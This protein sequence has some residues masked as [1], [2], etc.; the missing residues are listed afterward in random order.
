MTGQIQPVNAG[1]RPVGPRPPMPMPPQSAAAITPKEMIGIVKRHILLIISL[2]TIGLFAGGVGWYLCKKYIPKYSTTAFINILPDQEKD[3]MTMGTSSP[4]KDMYYA[5]RNTLASTIKQQGMLEELLRKDKIRET[6]WFRQFSNKKNS[7][8]EAV[9]DL[10]DNLGAGANRDTN[11]LKISMKCGDAKES[12][13]IVDEMVR[14]FI[15]KRQIMATSDIKAQL[16]KYNIQLRNLEKAVETAEQSMEGIRLGSQFSNLSSKTYFRSYIEEKVSSLEKSYSQLDTQVKQFQTQINTFRER[17][18]G[19]FDEVVREQMERDPIASGMRSRIASMQPHLA[20]LL[21]KFGDGHR[22]VEE[23]RVAI[24]QMNTDLAKRQVFIAETQR[25]SSLRQAEDMM[26]MYKTSLED[27]EAQRNAAMDEHKQLEEV[28][29]DY[30]KYEQIRETKQ[31]E[32]DLLSAHVQKLQMNHD[33]PLISKVQS[34]GPAPIPLRMKFPDIKMF[35]PAGLMLG[36]MLGAGI[37]F[38]VELLNDLLRTPT[39]ISK[40]LHIPLLGSIY[41]YDE[42]EDLDD[43]DLCHVVRQ[44]PYSIMSESYRQLRTNLQLSGSAQPHKT[45]FITSGAA[46]DGKTSV[47]VNLVSTLVAEDRKVLFID[48]NFRRPMSM[49]V[50]PHAENDGSMIEHADYG[51]SNY[52]MGQCTYDEVVRPG[53]FNNLDIVDSGPLPSN[54]AEILGGRNMQTL[55]DKSRDIYDY[56]IIDGPPLLLTD[57]KKLASIADGTIVVFNSEMTRRGTA[58]RTLRE[59]KRINANVVGTVL[60]GVKSMKGGYFHEKI[61]LY[62]EYQEAQITHPI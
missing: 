36:L 29:A 30:Y 56:V 50:F 1:I 21:V 62:Q 37:A 5:F 42:D 46:G 33:D 20:T 35:L 25:K 24:K 11:S 3:P 39:D 34:M 17:S 61:R 58:Q 8:L 19:E 23:T 27:L 7:V 54:P 49:E 26:L 43:I 51:L 22:R 44:A 48:T 12:A 28:K 41:H 14:L 4:N 59:L 2:A 38:A 16:G 13:V 18:E 10:E 52:L 47:A 57:A 6:K 15:S 40:H 45:F 55:L 60:I 31:G 53:G 9:E 32:L